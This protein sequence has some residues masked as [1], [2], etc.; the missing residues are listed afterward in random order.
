MMNGRNYNIFLHIFVIFY[1]MM[2][3]IK[4]TTAE[5]IADCLSMVTFFYLVVY[6]STG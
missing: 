5:V 6:L 1:S 2:I 3:H 4:M